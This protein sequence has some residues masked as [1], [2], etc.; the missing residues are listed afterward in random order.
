MV[1]W[2]GPCYLKHD[3]WK[4][5]LNVRGKWDYYRL[6]WNGHPIPFSHDSEEWAVF[7][8]TGAAEAFILYSK[9]NNLEHYSMQLLDGFELEIYNNKRSREREAKSN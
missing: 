1:G 6:N 2:N 7:P 8:T 5:I 3:S 9:D 4:Q